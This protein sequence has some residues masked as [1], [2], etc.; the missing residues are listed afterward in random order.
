[1]AL[2]QEISVHAESALEDLHALVHGIYPSLLLDRGLVDALKA[3]GRAAPMPVR[4]RTEGTSRR[5]PADV[6]AAVYF[7]CADALQNTAKHA[8][9]AATARIALRYEGSGL[10]FEVS[11]DGRGFGGQINAGSGL[12][13][14]EDRLT[15]VG[16]R[17]RVTSAPGRGTTVQ[18]WVGETQPLDSDSS[19]VEAT[20]ATP[21]RPAI[22]A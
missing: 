1:L 4:V 18:G 7:A 6:E 9:A 15:A 21:E 13:N 16:G 14:M 2:I 19:G 3:N 22:A 11:D 10:A 8:G 20:A 5:Y 17:L 12:T